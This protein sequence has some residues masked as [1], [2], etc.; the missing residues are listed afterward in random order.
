MKLGFC[1][2]KMIIILL[3]I[4]NAGC[5]VNKLKNPELSLVNARLTSVAIFETELGFTVRLQNENERPLD[6]KGAVYR[7]SLNGQYIGKGFEPDGFTLAPTSSDLRDVKVHL[8][9]L[10]MI[11]ELQK[12]LDRPRLDYQ[13]DATFYLEDSMGG[14]ELET[15]SVGRLM[16]EGQ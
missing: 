10:S 15:R 6:I 9:N 2:N 5:S 12:W 14:G 11:G 3:V 7:F 16:P 4:F 8:N 13:I 1:K